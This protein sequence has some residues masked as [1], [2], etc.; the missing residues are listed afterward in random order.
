MDRAP[1]RRL[2]VAL[3]LL[4]DRRRRLLLQHRTSDAWIMPDH[5]AFFGGAIEAS[6]TPE[7]AVRREA[8]EELGHVLQAPRLVRSVAYRHED[9]WGWI[10]VFAE[11][12]FGD[13]SRLELHE[14]QG[15]GWYELAETGALLMIERD[16]G[17]AAAVDAA[18]RG[19]AELDGEGGR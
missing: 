7:E 4:F 9:L 10:H 5:W 15:W 6:E 8:V 19:W 13:K 14:G 16:R 11:A 18:V 2:D 1:G 12:F 17:I 3:I